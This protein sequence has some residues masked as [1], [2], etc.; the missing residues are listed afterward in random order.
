MKKPITISLSKDVIKAMDNAHDNRSA[1]V[2]WL[3]REDLGLGY[4][5]ASKKES[6]HAG[7]TRN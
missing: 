1:Y 4:K 2:E 3:I 6:C 7:K 5:P